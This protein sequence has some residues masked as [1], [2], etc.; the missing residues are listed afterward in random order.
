M[1]GPINFTLNCSHCQIVIK[2]GRMVVATW[3]VGGSI[4]M[5]SGLVGKTEG[6][7]SLGKYRCICKDNIKWCVMGSCGVGANDGMSRTQSL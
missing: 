7:R 1:H 4:E 5:H 3:H 6:I 2:E